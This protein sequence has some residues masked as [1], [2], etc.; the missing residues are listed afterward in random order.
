MA[1]SQLPSPELLRKLL[2]YDSETGKLYWLQRDVSLFK[3]TAIRSS[4]H[5]CN[6]WNTRYSGAEAFTC[7]SNDGYCTGAI[8]GQTFRAHRVIWAIQSGTWPVNDV[9]HVNGIRNDNRWVNLRE[10]TRAQNAL[11]R[12]SNAGSSSGYV[13]VSWC[14]PNKK[15][16]VQ[17]TLDGVKKHVGL[18]QTEEEAASAFDAIR[19]NKNS[20]FVRKNLQ[21]A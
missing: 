6:L 8:F 9:D 13:G 17:T 18:F 3:E 4:S 19:A 2:R 16:R 1:K 21:E 15:W 7:M 20:E 14:A 12:R 10:A 5:S 11:N